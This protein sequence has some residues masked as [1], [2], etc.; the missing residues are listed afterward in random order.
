MKEREQREQIEKALHDLI[1]I[2]HFTENVSTKIHGLLD[3]AEIY[4]TVKEEFAKTKRYNATIFL[5]T[6]DRSRLRIVETSL[7]LARLKAAQR[8]SRVWVKED[9][10]DLNKSS[11]CSRVIREGRTVHVR[12][13]DIVGELLPRWLADLITRIIGYEK[14][15]TILT[16][17]KRH[18][19]IV[20]V[21]GVSSTEL[22]EQFIPSVRNLAQ[23]ISIALELAYEQIE[24]K[25]AEERLR[26]S[27]EKYRNLFENARDVIVTFDLEGNV[28]SVNKAVM[29]YGLKKD[30]IVGKNMLKFVSK[31][32]WPR[33]LRE[34]A[35]I[36][37]GN[38]IRGEIEIVTP[39]GKRVVDYRS[40]PIRPGK[41]VVGFQT[42]LRDITE[43]KRTEE[44]LA[45][46]RD[47]F[48]ALMD[49]I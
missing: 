6:D 43:R 8:A 42:I 1:E 3:E 12:V 25:R 16:P 18:G 9:T 39:K 31:R 22:A 34:L 35:E 11:I 40:T 7:P 13:S 27:E 49:N 48:Q 44:E 24:R 21:L 17:L 28:T 26:E 46:E 47:L 19:K 4:R 2:I 41:K 32:Y 38:A 45:R 20:G 14:R 36:T 23:H 15:S 30:E 37:R 10:I 33:L 5:L 29:E